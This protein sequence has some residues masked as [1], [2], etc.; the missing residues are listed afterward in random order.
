MRR[1]PGFTAEAAVY[2]GVRCTALRRL[3][4]P[5]PKSGGSPPSVCEHRP[6]PSLCDL[7]DLRRA[8]GLRELVVSRPQF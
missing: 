2:E 1:M 5:S 8:E 3:P 6:M 4:K 7:E